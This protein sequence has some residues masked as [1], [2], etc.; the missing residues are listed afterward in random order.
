MAGAFSTGRLAVGTAPLGGLYGA[1]SD[2]DAH[3][4]LTA[5]VAAGVTHFDTAPHYGRGLA[6]QRLGTFL[7]TVEHPEAFTVST[8]VGRWVHPTATRRDDDVFLGAPPGESVFD[9]SAAAVHAQLDES[10][11]RLG[12]ER[13][14]VALVHDPDDHLDEALGAFEA[15]S[16]ERASGRVGA[17]GV[18]TNSAAVVEHF[19]D[20]VELDVVVLAGRIT[21]LERSG[22]A[23]AARC[24]D[25]GI[26]LL[27]AGA[28]QS[29]IL[30]GGTADTYD[31]LPA[32]P[33]IRARVADLAA[34]CAAHDDTLHHVA[35]QHPRRVRGVASVLV[36]VRTPGEVRAAVDAL[37]RPVSEALWAA[38]DAVRARTR[39][40]A[41][42]QGDEQ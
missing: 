16:A 31:Y 11:R 29:G 24:A 8:K 21:L 5:A 23:V 6:E 34:V 28:L 36:G 30:A 41:E 9:F 39:D 3:D 13:I 17:I 33:S 2:H 14:D 19:L 18:G 26:T 4:T 25:T 32:P 7:G 20:R 10:R 27:A 38:I 40:R 37:E 22:E 42:E 1:I 12:R 35:L 15:L